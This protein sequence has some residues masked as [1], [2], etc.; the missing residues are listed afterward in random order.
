MAEPEPEVTPEPAPA[1]VEE[2]AAPEA[3]EAPI[4]ET[5]VAAL[6]PEPEVEK[7]EPPPAEALP[8]E[9]EAAE[10]GPASEAEREWAR[11]DA[12]LDVSGE[13]DAP[14]AAAAAEADGAE[15]HFDLAGV[16]IDGSSIYSPRDLLPTYRRYLGRDISVNDLYKISQAVTARYAADGY[17]ETT[18]VVPTQLI[19]SGVVTIRIQ[20]EFIGNIIIVD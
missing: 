8:A 11:I 1:A 6:E 17:G 5:V 16:I 19:R 18:A 10:T 9:E 4:A 13:N 3:P 2:P 15:M 20:E 7:I 14:A 12:A